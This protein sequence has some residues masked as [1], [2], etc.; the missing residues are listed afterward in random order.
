MTALSRRDR[1]ALALALECLRG[2]EWMAPDHLAS[3]GVVS[4][5]LFEAWW[6]AAWEAESRGGEGGPEWD[7][8]TQRLLRAR[9]A[10]ALRVLLRADA[11]DYGR[12]WW[13]C[14]A[15]CGAGDLTRWPPPESAPCVHCDE[16]AIDGPGVYVHAEYEPIR[17]MWE[18]APAHDGTS[19]AMRRQR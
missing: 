8:V 5:R 18:R 10:L 1:A 19:P 7:R 17:P 3:A 14:S 6:E 9:L 4:Q 16:G 13:H 12:R 11:W 2:G 15:E